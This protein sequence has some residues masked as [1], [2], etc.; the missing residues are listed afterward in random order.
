MAFKSGDIVRALK[1]RGYTP[2][3]VLRRLG[4]DENLLRGGD[5]SSEQVEQNLFRKGMSVRDIQALIDQHVAKS[6]PRGGG[7]GETVAD[8]DD[9]PIVRPATL[10]NE[11]GDDDPYREFSDYLQDCGLTQDEAERA[12]EIVRDSRRRGGANGRDKNFGRDVLPRNA[13]SRDLAERG[14]GMGGHLSGG[15]TEPAMDRAMQRKTDQMFPH[16]RTVTREIAGCEP[17][18]G[19]DNIGR[20][21][22]SKGRERFNQMFPGA[23]RIS[24]G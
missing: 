17:E 21:L 9:P 11:G 19:R 22:S 7:G 18:R 15:R 24:Q 4:L 1:K 10:Q 6:D 2:K 5:E 3:S 20:P 16:L 13:Q 14:G 8:D 23:S 12:C